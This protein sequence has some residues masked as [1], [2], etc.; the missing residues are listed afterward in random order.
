MSVAR[1]VPPWPSPF[2]RWPVLFT[3]WT[4]LAILFAAQFYISSS[5]AGVAVGW[6]RALGASLGDWYVV[7]ILS[8]PALLLARR[9]AFS[10]AHWRTGLLIHLVAGIA[11]SGAF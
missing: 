2:W 5:Q 1:S 7:A 11:F 10:R 9:F 8:W 3:A 4:L 6:R